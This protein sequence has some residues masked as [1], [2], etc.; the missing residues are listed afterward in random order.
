MWKENCPN[1]QMTLH[2]QKSFT[3]H[4]ITALDFVSNSV[5]SFKFLSYMTL[6]LEMLTSEMKS[7][8]KIFQIQSRVSCNRLAAGLVSVQYVIYIDSWL[9]NPPTPPPPW[10]CI[11]KMD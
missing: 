2:V 10:D 9:W 1:K 4:E 8:V 7:F 11:K 6:R 5:I 3:F